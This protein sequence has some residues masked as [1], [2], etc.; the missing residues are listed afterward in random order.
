MGSEMCIRDSAKAL[1]GVDPS[2]VSW[3]SDP[4]LWDSVDVTT[5]AIDSSDT[6]TI[7]GLA[8][9]VE[10]HSHTVIDFEASK[11]TPRQL[12]QCERVWW[13]VDRDEN[14]Q[15]ELEK[16][17]RSINEVPALAKRLQIVEVHQRAE[18]IPPLLTHSIELVHSPLRV[19]R[20]GEGDFFGLSLIHI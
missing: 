5:H 1:S 14:E 16:I 4:T 20:H 15:A 13:I 9:Q 10:N 11:A 3:S 2:I 18:K 19:Q 17:Q 6:D 12:L 8:E 7:S